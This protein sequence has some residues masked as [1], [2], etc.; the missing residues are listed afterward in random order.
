MTFSAI[1]VAM[2]L[3]ATTAAASE[4]S[5]SATRTGKCLWSHHVLPVTG[6]APVPPQIHPTANILANF[7]LVAGQELDHPTIAFFTTPTAAAAAEAKWLRYDQAAAN[8][9]Q[10]INHPDLRPLFTRRQNVVVV[11]SSAT[12]KAPTRRTVVGCLR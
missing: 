7:A 3:I 8:Q 1:A 10:G 4:S 11:W 9:V 6:Q 12:T 2:F 5:Y